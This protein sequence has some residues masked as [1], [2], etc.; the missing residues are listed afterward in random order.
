MGGTF[1]P[2][3]PFLPVPDPQQQPQP[4][5][6]AAAF[7]PSK[8]FDAL[9]QDDAIDDVAANR[10]ANL[11]RNKKWSRPGPYT[12]QLTPEEET[13][14]KGWVQK[15]KVPWDDQP[16]ADYDMRGYWLAQKQGN[17]LAVRGD[18]GHFPDRWKTPF[19]ATFSNQSQYALPGAP[20]WEGDKLVYSEPQEAPVFDASKPFTTVAP[21]PI[22]PGSD[23]QPKPQPGTFVGR[24]WNWLNAPLVA[25]EKVDAAMLAG[26]PGLALAASLAPRSW[27]DTIAQAA[28]KTQEIP[29]VEGVHKGL[30]DFVAGLT[31]PVMLGI[32]AASLG[33][34]SIVGPLVKAGMPEA[35]AIALVGKAKLTADMLFLTQFGYQLAHDTLPDAHIAWGDYVGAKNDRE[36]KL[37]LDR[38]TEIATQGVLGAVATGLSLRGVAKDL[39]EMQAASPKGKAAANT[40]YSSAIHNYQFENQIGNAQSQQIIQLKNAPELEA[41]RNIK[42]E[43]W[44]A[45]TRNVEAMGDPYVLEQQAREAEADPKRKE[46]AQ[47]FRDAKHLTPQEIGAR[48]YLRS[49]L[50]GDFKHLEYYGALPADS[51]KENYAPHKWDVDDVDPDTGELITHTL[52]DGGADM[53]KKRKFESIAAGEAAGFKPTTTHFLALVADYHE[54]VMNY[55]SR[56]NLANSLAGG[57]MD[58][59]APMSAPGHRFPGFTRPM[60]APVDPIELQRLRDQGKLED[61]LR[62]GRIYEI[63]GEPGR[64][65]TART[66]QETVEQAGGVYRG[67]KGG[68][69]EITLPD[70]MTD[71]LALDP[72]MKKFVSVTLPQEGLTVEK[73]QTALAKKFQEFGGN[74][75]E[76]RFVRAEIKPRPRY[77]WK[78]SDF[79][80]TGLGVWRPV[81]AEEAGSMPPG[82]EIVPMPRNG[83]PGAAGATAQQNVRVSPDDFINRVSS[84]AGKVN[85]QVVERYRSDIRAGRALPPAEIEFDENGNVTGANG[86][87]RALAY[88]LEGH[89]RMP[90]AIRRRGVGGNGGGGEGPAPGEGGAPKIANARVELYANPDVAHHLIPML[91]SAR[92]KNPLVRA[93]LKFSSENKSDLLALSPFHWDTILNRALESG[94]N[95]VRGA[96][97]RFVF[98]PKALDYFHPTDAQLDAMKNGVVV[99]STRPGFGGYLSEGLGSSRESLIN[100]IPLVGDFN[101]AIEE[102]LFGP[103]GWITSLKFDLYDRLKKEIQRSSPALTD[104]QVGRVAASQVNNKFGGLNYTLMGRSASTQNA[105]R[106]FLLAPDFLESSGRSIVDLASPHGKTLVKSL[107]AYNVARWLLARGVNY[108]VSGQTR[109]EAGFDVLSK[110][111]KRTY[112]MRHTL[113]D[114]LHFANSPRDFVANRVNPLLVRAPEEIVQGEDEFGHKVSDVQ[115][116]WD[117][118][119]QVTPIP[120]QGIYPTQQ[121]TQPAPIDKILQAGGIESR[122]NFTPAELEAL[123]LGSKREEGAPLEGADLARA[124]TRFRLENALRTAIVARDVKAR[125]RAM[126]EIRQATAGGRI[127]PEESSKMIRQAHEYP[128][129]LQGAAARLGLADVLQVWDKAGMS[130]RREIRP[131]VEKKI[132][133]WMLGAAKHPAAERRDM[134]TRIDAYRRS[135]AE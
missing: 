23:R 84:P 46:T 7:D 119:R 10:E 38:F 88:K 77:M 67:S 106:A 47:Q 65:M 66:P 70:S 39:H 6:A 114:F 125:T 11:A 108:L 52:I 90:V 73:V 76:A 5:P 9:P 58:D 54:K 107:I 3:L 35:R 129:M 42:P 13:E 120:L 134:R 21:P 83:A 118:L 93:L 86:R 30:D 16:D 60:D 95:V 111:G 127:T 104:E 12:T 26:V 94:M 22:Q 116:F 91:E 74:P 82:T 45:I 27:R 41:V 57:T 133:N 81:S 112:S 31:S 121:V 63:A 4:P 61:L 32:T 49:I 24:A 128:T 15:N 92:P 132:Q 115:A 53:L 110:D 103:H 18:N 40:D 37:A 96:N 29:G 2:A 8:P 126:L 36:R 17:K 48:D 25:P 68:L 72:R 50:Q 135:A 130:E 20:H 69:V 43:R 44:S 117:T 28:Q 98:M 85:A 97:R 99:A 123:Q 62:R 55:V 80:P 78:Q 109:P 124:Q 101:R 100:R 87:H 56:N 75:Q 113:G 71:K 64:T 51:F 89:D 131:I 59:G 79:V 33:S 14:F 34:D 19:D 122:K 1:N 105:L 102:K